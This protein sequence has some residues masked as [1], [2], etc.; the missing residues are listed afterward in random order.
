MAPTCDNFQRY[1]ISKLFQNKKSK[2]KMPSL[3][4]KWQSI[5]RELDEDEQSSS[6]E[7]EQRT[8]QAHKRIE[9]W[10]QHQLIR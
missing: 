10:K 3:V 5:Q 2:T 4:K 7:D 6:S 9:E 8:V 1:A